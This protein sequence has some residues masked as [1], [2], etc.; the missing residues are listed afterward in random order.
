[1][2]IKIN[3]ESLDAFASR[4]FYLAWQACGG[5]LGMGVFQDRPGASEK[6]VFNNVITAGDYAGAFGRGKNEVYGDYVFGRMM[7]FGFTILD[8]GVIQFRNTDFRPDYQG[9]SRKYPTIEALLKAT[10]EST[11]IPYEVVE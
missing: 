4:L 5:P 8:D 7:K 10:V 11:G 9:F 1:M 2:K 3:R 6:D